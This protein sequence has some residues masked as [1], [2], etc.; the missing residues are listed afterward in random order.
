M[1]R[2]QIGVKLTVDG[3]NLPFRIDSFM[4]RLIM[5]KAVYLAQAAGVHLG[6]Y[7]H[8][9]L[10]GPYSRSLTRDEFAIATDISA[11]L[12]QSEGWKLDDQSS[13]RL[14]QIHGLFA[15]ADRD[16][17]AKKLE[18]LA[19]VHFLIDRKQ[20]SRADCSQVAA[21]LERFNKD[22]SEGDVKKA[23]EELKTYG[24]LTA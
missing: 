8:W 1:D 9:Y 2:Q 24:L 19:S 17:L 12:D 6:Y 10:Y 16:K 14:G 18:L 4:D 21:T 15:E 3:L 23:L 11:G 13:Q 7:Y 20:V 22:F 5:Q